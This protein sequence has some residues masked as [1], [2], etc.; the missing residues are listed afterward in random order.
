MVRS[1]GLPHWRFFTPDSTAGAEETDD[2][3]DDDEDPFN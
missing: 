1:N 2:M 3:I